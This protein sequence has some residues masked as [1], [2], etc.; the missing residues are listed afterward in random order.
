MCT[1][2]HPQELFTIGET[3]VMQFKFELKNSIFLP[4]RDN[5]ENVESSKAQLVQ[6]PRIEGIHGY[7]SDMLNPSTLAVYLLE[8]GNVETRLIFG[9]TFVSVFINL[10]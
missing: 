2:R 10:P 7:E 6:Y 9:I 1:I 4:I 3:N 5:I 8:R